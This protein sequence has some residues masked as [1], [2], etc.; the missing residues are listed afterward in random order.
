MDN[1]Y[2]KRN[3][4]IFSQSIEPGGAER[5]AI[6]LAEALQNIHV[7]FLV[8]FYK[9][10]DQSANNLAILN[11]LNV[12]HIELKGNFIEKIV[13]LFGLLRKERIEIIFSYLLLPNFL[14]GIVG[15][16]AGVKHPTGGVRS[17][18]LAKKKIWINKMLQN[19]VNEYTIYNNW[20]GFQKYTKC[21]FNPSR[22]VLI[23]NCIEIKNKPITRENHGIVTVLSVG[24]FSEPKD[25][26]T[27]LLSIKLLLKEVQNI[28]FIIIGYGTLLS[29]IKS[30]IIELD[31]SEYVELIINPSNKDDYYKKSDIF[32]LTSVFEG[33]SNAAMEAMSYSLPM[34][35]T[36]VGD[37]GK[38][39]EKDIRFLCKAKDCN[40]IAR[41]LEI[42]VRNQDLRNSYGLRNYETICKNYSFEHFKHTYL[43]FIDSL[44]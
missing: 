34:V 35:L 16:L 13:A 42:L 14:G 10:N 17:S 24:R 11:S 1:S 5:Q 33:L 15:R 22:A 23:Y 31:L 28:R 40:S 7:V 12:T 9:T 26:Y 2:D 37:N 30:W 41:N 20:H 39:I 29:A 19:Y 6:Y 44:G 3:I 43:T 36:D 27:S 18:K 32:L 8:T 4:V 21:G 25:Y 38:L